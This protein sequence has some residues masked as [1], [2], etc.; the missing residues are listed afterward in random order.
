MKRFSQI[1]FTKS[2]N[3]PKIATTSVAELRKSIVIIFVSG[4]S[5][6]KPLNFL[7]CNLWR[8]TDILTEFY[9]HL[10]KTLSTYCTGHT[11][12][13]WDVNIILLNTQLNSISAATCPPTA[14]SIHR[15]CYQFVDLPNYYYYSG[16]CV[17]L[18][19]SPALL[20]CFAAVAILKSKVDKVSPTWLSQSP[21]S[22]FG[23]WVVYG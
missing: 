14:L 4:S 7:I 5:F 20:L 21:I 19:G 10:E 17:K 2:H 9:C 22:Y 13:G 11:G 6:V 16:F 12:T 15:V 1:N 3:S 8:V 23:L 18:F